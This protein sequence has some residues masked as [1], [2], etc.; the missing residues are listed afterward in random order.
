VFADGP[1]LPRPPEGGPAEVESTIPAAGRGVKRSEDEPTV[2]FRS[3]SAAMHDLVRGNVNTNPHADL[4]DAH[5]T[6]EGD[7]PYWQEGSPG[8]HDVPDALPS[9][10]PT[11]L[12]VGAARVVVV[13][14]DGEEGESFPV[15]GPTVTIGR[16]QGDII[17]PDDNFMSAAH[18]RLERIGDTFT[19]VDLGS[20]NGVY[21]R[22]RG[23]SPAFP[24]DLFMVGHQVLRLEN[25]TESVEE[26]PPSGDGTR[27]FGTPLKPAWAKL[28]LVG[29]GGVPGDTYYLRG[30]KV[31]FGRE[32]GDILFPQDPFVSRE[33][34]RLRLEIHGTA[35]SV[36]L[37]DLGS[38]NGTYI[39]IRGNT[40]LRG[41]DTFRIGDQILRLRLDR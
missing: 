38:A 5:P 27:L 39:R 9:D 14:R 12:G 30:A 11:N 29:R 26:Q 35:M 23:S 8:A 19:L 18:A 33:H 28:A 34:A 17:F 32:Q 10:R 15:P 13:G 40:E 1:P 16:Q 37:E 25:I 7:L 4:E 41:R 3:D 21:K 24:G 31:V 6:L 2:P 36:F 22:I 20:P